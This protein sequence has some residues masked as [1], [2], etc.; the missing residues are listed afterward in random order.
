MDE[1]IGVRMSLE[2][3]YILKGKKLLKLSLAVQFSVTQFVLQ[4]IWLL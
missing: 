4:V 2:E 3:F 1:N